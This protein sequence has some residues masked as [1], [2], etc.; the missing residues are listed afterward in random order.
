MEPDT[1]EVWYQARRE[2]PEPVPELLY[3]DT[4]DTDDYPELVSE[5]EDYDGD[6]ETEE[7]PKPEKQESDVDQP[8]ATQLPLGKG[9]YSR[10]IKEDEVQAANMLRCAADR[11]AAFNAETKMADRTIMLLDSGASQT[12][13]HGDNAH[14]SNTNTIRRDPDSQVT[15]AHAES[16]PMQSL[17]RIDTEAALESGHPI[18]LP[19]AMLL[20]KGQ[21][22]QQLLSVGAMTD[23]NYSFF[24]HQDHCYILKDMKVVQLVPKSHNLYPISLKPPPSGHRQQPAKRARATDS[25]RTMLK[26]LLRMQKE[27][28]VAASFADS[29][30]ADATTTRQQRGR[31]SSDVSQAS[32]GDDS[33]FHVNQPHVLGQPEASSSAIA[34]HSRARVE[35][36]PYTQHVRVDFET[37]AHALNDRS[38]NSATVAPNEEH[39]HLARAFIGQDNFKL[40]L[41]RVFAHQS[42]AKGT[43]LYQSLAEEYG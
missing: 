21:L 14:M 12:Y 2:E 17:G 10:C 3:P 20:D 43:R 7:G 30:M 27:S 8:D 33:P 34:Q 11:Q 29:K 25:A 9:V 28:K 32:E 1:D 23:H 18:I 5:C 19:D 36:I 15:S 41:H 26:E 39:A 38:S 4:D 6:S 40:Y 37:D 13:M 35:I 31:V 22:R 42:V 16:E 24:F